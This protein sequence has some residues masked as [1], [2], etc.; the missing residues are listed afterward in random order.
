MLNNTNLQEVNILHD[1][2]SNDELWYKTVPINVYLY[3]N[4]HSIY[5]ELKRWV[6]DAGYYQ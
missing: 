5:Q 6:L 3:D 2:I 1:I 4:I